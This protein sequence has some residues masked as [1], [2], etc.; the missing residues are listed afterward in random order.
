VVVT[1]RRDEP[2]H[3]LAAHV[4]SILWQVAR[5]VNVVVSIPNQF[6]Y[7]PLHAVRATKT[8]EPDRLNLYT[9]F[10][11][12]SGECGEIQEVILLDEW[13]I[14]HN[15]EF[16]ENAHLYPAKVPKNFMGF[17]IKVGTV[18]IDPYV[19]MTENYTQSVGRIPYKLTGLSVELLKLVC[20]KMNLTVFLVASLN[21]ELHSY[22]KEFTELDEGLSNVLTGVIPLIPLVLTSSFDVTVPYTH[23]KVKMLVPCPKT[24]PGTE[25]LMKTFSLSVWLTI[26]LVLQLT[27]A[28]F[29]LF[30]II[31][32]DM[33]HYI[34]LS[35]TTCY[36]H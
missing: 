22:A 36:L 27:T 6:A 24:I 31:F 18:G 35:N 17:P 7:R 19:T 29:W 15:G 21:M 14:E 20:E 16:S 33:L 34:I 23:V 2:P 5:I 26:G 3:L 12:K 4:C 25:K 11:F 8:T 30:F 10:P 9:W 13:V 1:E 32:I 28:V